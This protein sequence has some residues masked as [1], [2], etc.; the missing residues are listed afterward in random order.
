MKFGTHILDT[1]LQNEI[2]NQPITTQESI[3]AP[4]IIYICTET[5][6]ILLY[7]REE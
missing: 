7:N 5:S 4:G 3:C 2:E 1:K 6:I